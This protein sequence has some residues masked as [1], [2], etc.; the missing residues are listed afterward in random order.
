M[1]E[2]AIMI[3]GQDGHTWDSFQWVA[4][5][6]ERMGFPALYRSDHYI[7][8][9]GGLHDSLDLWPSLTWLATQTS[10]IEFGAMVTP[11]SFRNPVEMVRSAMH[12]DDLSGGRLQF[13]VGAGWQAREHDMFGFHLGTI[14][15]RMDRFEEALEVMTLLLRSDQ[16]VSFEGHYYQLRDAILLPR[17]KR[18]GGPPIV[19]GGS[20]PK[21]TLPLVAKY[22]D[23]WNGMGNPTLWSEKNAE[24]DR[25]LAEVGRP[26][27]A[28]R[29]TSMKFTRMGETEA[30]VEKALAGQD[31]AALLERGALIGTPA[32]VA[33]Q[34]KSFESAGLQRVMLQLMDPDDR[35]MAMAGEVRDRLK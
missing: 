26:A 3:E 22:A 21:R 5:E 29:R 34:L 30:E 14:K 35:K 6:T 15:E 18:A 31:R 16:P 33:E 23:E 11:V 12:I 9:Q 32:Q 27:S 4:R 10:T 2:V 28:V 1:I 24:L 7:N 25:L 19:I 17:P 13:G 8:P 20:G